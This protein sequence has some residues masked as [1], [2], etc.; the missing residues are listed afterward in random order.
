MVESITPRQFHESEGIEEWRVLAGE[1]SAFFRTESFAR[2]VELVKVIGAL[3]DAANHHPDVDL[4]YS[5]VTVRLS[6]HEIQGLSARDVS[7]AREITTAA[8]ELDLVAEPS[9]GEEIQVAIDALDIPS[10]RAFWRAALNYQDRG[11]DQLVDPRAIGPT[12]WFQQMDVPR[13]ERN[14]VH[15]DICVPHDEA[16]RRVAAVLSAGGRL[17]TDRFAPSWWVLADPE[18]NEACVATWLERE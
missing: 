6:T 11:A 17:V 10:V 7:L 13:P 2:G 4:R 8:R 9:R 15:I 5:S 12:F 1:I 16:E 18:G 3:A 14:C